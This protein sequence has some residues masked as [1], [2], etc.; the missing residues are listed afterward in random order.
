MNYLRVE[1]EEQ[2][3]PSQSLNRRTH[4]PLRLKRSSRHL[5]RSAVSQVC[6]EEP[7]GPRARE[8]EPGAPPCNI[9]VI[10]GMVRLNDDA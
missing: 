8:E 6:E 10:D 7:G 4:A 5:S 9:H 3:M 2:Q 1:H